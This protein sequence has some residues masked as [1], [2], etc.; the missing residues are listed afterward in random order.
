[1][2]F[3]G[4]GHQLPVAEFAKNSDPHAPVAQLLAELLSREVDDELLSLL[5][6]DG[7]KEVLAAGDPELAA[8][9]EKTWTKTDFEAHAVEFCRLFIY[10]A[11]AP[12]RPEHWLKTQSGEQFSIRRWFAEEDLPELAPHLA[13]LPDTHVAKIL[14]VRAG[15]SGAPEEWVTQYEAE[16]ISPW[17]E[18]F[19]AALQGKSEMALYRGLGV[20]LGGFG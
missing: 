1:M 2:D 9:L 14:A 10:P 16:M 8:C 19:S 17:V 12:A 13:E 3:L 7:V 20:V 18:A 15:V 11:V 4:P 6:A 5:Q